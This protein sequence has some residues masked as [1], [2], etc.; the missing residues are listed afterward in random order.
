MA[1]VAVNY[2]LL[3][4]SGSRQEREWRG[5]MYHPTPRCWQ[6]SASD[7]IV[8][9]TRG[10]HFQYNSRY[11]PLFSL[12]YLLLLLSL[13]FF[14]SFG[15]FFGWRG[16]WLLPTMSTT[17]Q[18]LNTYRRLL[19]I[20]QKKS[21]RHSALADESVMDMYVLGQNRCSWNESNWHVRSVNL[22][23]K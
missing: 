12:T 2:P 21:K 18:S 17:T 7:L 10:I 14:R 9:E 22:G 20:R 11:P 6:P 23:G 4:A 5:F 13:F 3:E 8:H 19:T 16:L 15:F 1:A